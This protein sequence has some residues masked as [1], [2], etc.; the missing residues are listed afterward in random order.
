M[1]MA[2]GKILSGTQVDRN[3]DLQTVIALLIEKFGAIKQAHEGHQNLLWLGGKIW[4]VVTSTDD[5][6]L[7]ICAGKR[8]DKLELI[9]QL[10]SLHAGVLVLRQ[11]EDNLLFIYLI[12]DIEKLKIHSTNA[13][14]LDWRTIDEIK[15]FSESGIMIGGE[16]IGFRKFRQ[17]HTLAILS[18]G[19]TER[20]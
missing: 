8:C 15:L 16:L 18:S 10:N 13:H 20:K 4:W 9:H 11:L 1:M 17:L 3:I 12:N 5:H 19:K 7:D 2:Y 14:T 6:A